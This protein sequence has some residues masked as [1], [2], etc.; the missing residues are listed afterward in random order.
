MTERF[1]KR[2]LTATGT[3][4]EGDEEEEEECA[5]TG[6][7]GSRYMRGV[8]RLEEMALGEVEEGTAGHTSYFCECLLAGSRSE[9]E[10]IWESCHKVGTCICEAVDSS[11]EIQ[12]DKKKIGGLRWKEG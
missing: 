1:R 6:G 9:K 4:S 2:S 10:V 8:G 12:T 7:A 5:V 3:G 11:F